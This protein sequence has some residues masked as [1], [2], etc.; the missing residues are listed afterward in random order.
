[1]S[2]VLLKVFGILAILVLFIALM[3][4]AVDLALH[5]KVVI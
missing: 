2:G 4:F 5:K 3:V 1:M